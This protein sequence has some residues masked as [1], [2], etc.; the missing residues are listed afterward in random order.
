MSKRR[1]VAVLKSIPY[2]LA[3]TIC[4]VATKTPNFDSWCCNQ[5]GLRESEQQNHNRNGGGHDQNYSMY[6]GVNEYMY[7]RTV[8]KLCMSQLLVWFRIFSVEVRSFGKNR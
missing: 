7:I 4:R 1:L 8:R 2:S 3:M 5:S 6:Y